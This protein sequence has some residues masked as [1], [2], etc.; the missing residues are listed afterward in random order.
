[1]RPGNQPLTA[2]ITRCGPIL[3]IRTAERRHLGRA[4]RRPSRRFCFSEAKRPSG[5]PPLRRSSRTSSGSSDDPASGS[6]IHDERK[7][8]P[9]DFSLT[10]LLIRNGS[11]TVNGISAESPS[12]FWFRS[13][14]AVIVGAGR[15]SAL[16]DPLARSQQTYGAADFRWFEKEHSCRTRRGMRQSAGRATET[17][18]L[19]RDCRKSQTCCANSPTRPS[20]C[21]NRL[22]RSRAGACWVRAVSGRCRPASLRGGA[23]ARR[24]N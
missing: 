6:C 2:R 21:R 12:C 10:W 11:R 15:T 22:H 14:R 17:A 4:T 19:E 23:A 16:P 18:Q 7:S 20:G 3:A 13:R 8:E 9:G 1:M 5:R 24:A